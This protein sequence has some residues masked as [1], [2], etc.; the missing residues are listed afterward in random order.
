MGMFRYR[1][2]SALRYSRTLTDHFKSSSVSP[3]VSRSSVLSASGSLLIPQPIQQVAASYVSIT[4][5]LLNAHETWEQA[6]QIALTGSGLLQELDS[7]VG[8]LSLTSS[9][10]ALVRYARH[11]LHWIRLDTQKPR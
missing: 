1:R 8:P 10:S 6:D 2:E 3:S 5:L 7:A 9:M 4:A 11:G